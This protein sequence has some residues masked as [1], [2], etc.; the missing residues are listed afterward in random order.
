VAQDYTGCVVVAASAI[1]TTNGQRVS[2]PTTLQRIDSLVIPPAWKN[3][4]ICPYPPAAQS[5]Q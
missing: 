3:V 5:H 1:A 2:S 4:W